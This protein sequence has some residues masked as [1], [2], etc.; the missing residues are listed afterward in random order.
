MGWDRTCD[1][2]DHGV[3]GRETRRDA[4]VAGLARR[5]GIEDRPSPTWRIASAV[6]FG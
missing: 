2:V 4:V 1:A 3:G 6:R 5:R